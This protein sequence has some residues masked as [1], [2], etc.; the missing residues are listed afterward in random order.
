MFL[1]YDMLTFPFP[2]PLDAL[3]QL[4]VSNRLSPGDGSIELTEFMGPTSPGVPSRSHY[5]FTVLPRPVGVEEHFGKGKASIL[6]V[7]S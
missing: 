5:S 2:G 3:S 1:A 6:Q 7:R 4:E